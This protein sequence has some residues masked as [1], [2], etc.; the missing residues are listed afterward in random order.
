MKHIIIGDLHGKDYWQEINIENYDKV[1]FLGDYVDS[2]TASNTVIYENLENIINLKKRNPDK[3]VLLLGNHDIQ[4]LYFPSYQ[5]SGFR[6]TMQA[7]LTS[8]FNDNKDLFQIAY[9]KG[10]YIFSHAG[11][12]NSWYQEFLRIP[13]LQ[14]IKD[15]NDTLADLLNKVNQTGQRYILHAAGYFRGGEGN[16]GITWADKKETTTD[17]LKGYHQVVGHTVVHAVE[18]LQYTDRS[19]TYIDVLDTVIYFH[20]LDC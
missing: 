9:Q 20:E 11:I 4:Y 3:M 12:T 10:N 19:I 5:C 2:F 6:P 17:M 7:E 15:E 8:L 13:I 16:G 14:K 1:V 18:T